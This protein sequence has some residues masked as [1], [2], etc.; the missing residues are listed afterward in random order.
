MEDKRG[1]GLKEKRMGIKRGEGGE[2]TKRSV[3]GG[4]IRKKTARGGYLK[5]ETVGKKG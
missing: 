5:G 1:K 4:G 2:R 3:G